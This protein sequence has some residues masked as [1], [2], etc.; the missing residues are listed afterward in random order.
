MNRSNKRFIKNLLLTVTSLAMITMGSVY[1]QTRSSAPGYMKDSEGNIMRDNEGN[2]THTSSWT[3]EMATIVG[4]DGVTLDTTAELIMGAPSGQLAEVTIP[5]A[6]LF[7]FDSAKLTDEGKVVLEK[8]REELRPELSDAY[9]AL[10]VGH[11][12][13]S[14]DP[15]YNVDLSKRRAQTVL[16]QLVTM[17]V[18]AD[19][20]RVMGMGDVDP[21]ASND[22]LEGRVLNRRVE[23]VV[24]GELRALDM[25][26]FPSAI[27]FPRRSAELSPQGKVLIVQDIE[28]AMVILKR[29]NY[30]EVVGHTDDVGEGDYNLDL[31]EQR[32][33]VVRDFLV[34]AGVNPNKIMAWGAGKNLPITSNNTPEGRTENRRVEILMLGRVR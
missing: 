26:R 13:S 32:A 25:L 31:S 7:K 4:C 22:T 5:A 16:D 19:M 3:P 24:I 34:K 12:D 27:L 20:L 11:T 10:I 15:K 33:A 1:A 17:G 29:A 21:I 6:S 18:P 9:A 14:G 30:I 23:V 2:C 28:K 8:Y